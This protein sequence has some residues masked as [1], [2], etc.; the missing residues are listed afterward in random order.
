MIHLLWIAV[1]T[2][3]TFSVILAKPQWTDTLT[4]HRARTNDKY[5]LPPE[6]WRDINE[7]EVMLYKMHEGNAWDVFS[8]INKV[9]DKYMRYYM[10]F[11]YD[12]QMTR[13]IQKYNDKVLLLST[14]TK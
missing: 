12:Q 6:F 8:A 10:N 4:K 7:L 14:K 1:V 9:R 13:L 11:T 3:I 2:L 5:K